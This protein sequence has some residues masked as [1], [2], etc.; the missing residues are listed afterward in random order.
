M[1]LIMI[2]EIGLDNNILII[3]K[4]IWLRKSHLFRDDHL[5]FSNYDIACLDL[6]KNNWKILISMEGGR[7]KT[8]VEEK[9][10]KQLLPQN[11]ICKNSKWT[12]ENR[13]GRF[14]KGPELK[15]K[16]LNSSSFFGK[17]NG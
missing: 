11:S 17:Y 12:L 8:A 15:F 9:S 2:N 16:A 1:L 4:Q 5:I 6:W 10:A 13:I 7:W 14:F 3:V